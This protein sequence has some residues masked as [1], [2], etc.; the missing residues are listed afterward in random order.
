MR[1]RR[2]E[3]EYLN[4]YVVE[5][6]PQGR[7]GRRRSTRRSSRALPPR[8]RHAQARSEEPRA[9]A[10]APARMM[11]IGVSEQ[12]AR[13]VSDPRQGARFMVER[14]A[15]ARRAGLD[16]LFVG[17]HHAT[18]GQYYQNVPITARMLAEWGDAPAGL[19]VPAAAVEPGAAR[20][21]GRHAGCDRRRPLHHPGRPRR[22]RGP[23][24]RDGHD[25]QDT[26]LGVRGIA[27]HRA[28]AAEG[29]SRQLVR[30][31]PLP[32][33]AGGAASRRARRRVDRLQRAAG[34]RPRRATGRRLAGRAGRHAE[35]ARAQ[36]TLYRER[37]AAHGRTPTAIAVR[38]D[39]YVAES[40]RRRGRPCGAWPPAIAGSIRAR[41]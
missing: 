17:D 30:A 25:A 3:I 2:T 21:A 20:R 31:L 10:Q 11:R 8:R 26:A 38:R 32:R 4:G 18:P 14:A 24:R 35:Q 1:G 16:S 28:P 41:W 33:R 27:R 19:P 22:R 34:H 15:A 12:S 9:D 13:K 36:I 6:G 7:G 37:C 40:T 5:R 39:I 29:R 23:V